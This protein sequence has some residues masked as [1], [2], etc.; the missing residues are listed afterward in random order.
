MIKFNVIINQIDS[1]HLCAH[2]FNQLIVQLY[3][4]LL[5]DVEMRRASLTDGR[6]VFKGVELHHKEGM[7]IPCYHSSR[8]YCIWALE[9]KALQ[10]LDGEDL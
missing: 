4:K 8:G 9:V 1:Q 10:D 2:V 7:H 5:S 6:D 3:L